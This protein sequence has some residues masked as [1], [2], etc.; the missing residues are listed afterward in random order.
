[1]RTDLLREDGA[2][3][4][5]LRHALAGIGQSPQRRSPARRAEPA[6]AGRCRAHR[7]AHRRRRRP[8]I[9]QTVRQWDDRRLIE[10][11]ELAFGRDLQFIRFNGTLV[12]GLIGL[13]LHALITLIPQ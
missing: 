3:A 10:Q 7:R 13:V 8:H 6:P 2:V 5:H 11:L 1:V 4:A 9:A 12:G